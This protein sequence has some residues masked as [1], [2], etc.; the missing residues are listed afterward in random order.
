M[1]AGPKVNLEV[2]PRTRSVNQI[3]GTLTLGSTSDA[4]SRVSSGE[5]RKSV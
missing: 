5:S 1:A 2:P 4:A 3:S